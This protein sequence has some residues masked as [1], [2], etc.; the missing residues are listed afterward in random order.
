VG[1][2]EV[3]GDGVDDACGDGS[4]AGDGKACPTASR[5]GAAMANTNI[6]AKKHC[7]VTAIIFQNRRLYSLMVTQ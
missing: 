7:L 5:P 2:V 4:G 6:A 1:A 3:D